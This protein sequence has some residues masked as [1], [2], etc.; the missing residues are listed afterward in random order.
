MCIF[1][2][3]KLKTHFERK[4]QRLEREIKLQK[5]RFE[6]AEQE[7]YAD[8]LKFHSIIT[9]GINQTDAYITQL[10]SDRDMWRLVTTSLLSA[11]DSGNGL[12]EAVHDAKQHLQSG[13]FS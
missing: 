7:I 1:G 9:S 8:T 10:K 6:A 11:L 12:I 2:N 4:F 5:E 13:K 3:E